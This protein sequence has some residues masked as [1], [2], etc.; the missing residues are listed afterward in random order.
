VELTQPQRRTYEQLIGIGS[1]P[2]FPADLEQDL[3]HRIEDGIQGLDLAEQ[4]WLGK[5][6][7]ND[8]ARC[9]GKFLSAVLGEGP[10]VEH[11]AK[12]AAGVLLHR[13]IEVDVGAR[14]AL[15]PHEIA[16]R[17]A[18]RLSE[19]EE[20]FSEYWSDLDAG[21]QD[22]QLMEVVRGVTLF[23]ASF[24]PLRELRRDL[25]PI[26]ELGV[27]AELGE[28]RL[29]LSGKIDLV[30]G[31][32]DRDSA[33]HATRLAIDLKTGGA[34]PEYPEDMRFYALVMTLRF[35]VPPYRA[36]S[37]F[38]DS[39]EWQAEDVTAETLERAAD[40]VIAAAASAASLSAGAEPSLVPGPYCGWCPRAEHC[41]AFAAAS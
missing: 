18:E 29:V 20:R 23:Q 36:A 13:A 30:L 28:G 32:P 14:E 41:P 19:R 10:P 31:A 40:R 39:G 11:S 8:H 4:L 15:D 7:L 22:E 27:K 17:A 9:E 34:Y 26:A 37:F 21:A 35:G 1:R 3:R 24:P 25:M 5:E 38:L 16:S 2:T 33:N 12:S 6:K